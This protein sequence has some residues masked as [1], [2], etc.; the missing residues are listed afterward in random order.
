MQSCS[1]ACATL[2]SALLAH[3]LH[4][5]ARGYDGAVRRRSQDEYATSQ[6][7]DKLREEMKDVPN[8]SI[9]EPVYHFPKSFV[10]ILA[11]VREGSATK[12]E[13]LL[14]EQVLAL[15]VE[16]VREQLARPKE[17]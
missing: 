13:L 5:N 3:S 6:L 16:Q 1:C 7:M 2:A 15:M 17:L 10:E 4:A 12:E 11:T 14:R 8:F 9:D